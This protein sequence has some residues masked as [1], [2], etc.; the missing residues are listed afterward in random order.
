MKF[1]STCRDVGNAN[2][3]RSTLTKP[4]QPCVAVCHARLK[5]KDLKE[6]ENFM[7][8]RVF[9]PGMETSHV[10]HFMTQWIL[11][12]LVTLLQGSCG[13]E[14]MTWKWKSQ[15]DKIEIECATTRSFILL[16]MRVL[17]ILCKYHDSCADVA[18]TINSAYLLCWLMHPKQLWLKADASS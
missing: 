17:L 2:E 6:Y 14:V 1:K 8:H 3:T 16:A 12:H 11:A 15:E 9:Q 4:M 18:C 5:I 7:S 13:L 10:L